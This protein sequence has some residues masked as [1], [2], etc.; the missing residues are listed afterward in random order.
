MKE[1][2][3]LDGRA[4]SSLREAGVPLPHFTNEDSA[5]EGEWPKVLGQESGLAKLESIGPKGLGANW[6]IPD[7]FQII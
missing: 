5:K 7:D 1:E 6:Q 2:L 4:R 3:E